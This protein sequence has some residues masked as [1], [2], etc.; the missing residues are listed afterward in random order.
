LPEGAEMMEYFA[1]IGGISIQNS[2]NQW[3][4]YMNILEINEISKKL[5]NLF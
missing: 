2:G 3:D 4:S 1:F 5:N